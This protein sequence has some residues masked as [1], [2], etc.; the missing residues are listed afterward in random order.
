MFT[1]VINTSE[2]KTFD[3]DILMEL[4]GYNKIRWMT[5]RLDLIGECAKVISESQNVLSADEFRVAVIVDFFGFD[6]IRAPYGHNGFGKEEGV[7]S[8][9]YLPYIDTYLIDNFIRKLEDSDIVPS[10]FE[11]YYVQ[12]G[13]HEKFSFLGNQ[14]EQLKQIL[15]GK[16]STEEKEDLLRQAPDKF[17]WQRGEVNTD[18]SKILTEELSLSKAEAED[19][20]L[21]KSKGETLRD[22]VV[23]KEYIDL[24]EIFLEKSKLIYDANSKYKYMV[25]YYDGVKT[26]VGA[27]QLLN[28]DYVFEKLPLDALFCKI[29]IIDPSKEKLNKTLEAEALDG[30]V[31][32]LTP[33]YGTYELHCTQDISLEFNITDYPYGA[34]DEKLTVPQFVEGFTRRSTSRSKVRRHHYLTSYGAGPARAAFDTLSLSLYLIRLYEREEVI[35]SEELEVKH[36]DADALKDV[37]ETS[38]SKISLAREVAS[39]NQS[40][41]YSLIQNSNRVEV[42]EDLVENKERILERILVNLPKEI[43]KHRMSADTLYHS[44]SK[45]CDIELAEQDNREEFDS[46][47]ANYL[48]ARD[49][50]SENNIEA[51]FEELKEMNALAMTDQC[52]SREEFNYVV[53]LREKDISNLF[54]STLKAE[55]LEVDYSKEKERADKAYE[56]YDRARSCLARNIFAD[57]AVFVLAILVMFVPYQLLQLSD[58]SSLSLGANFLRIMSVSIFAVLFI[59]AMLIRIIPLERQKRRAK[60]TLND[61][62]LE[63]HAKR[64]YSFEGLRRRYEKE[65]IQI[66]E[67]RYEIHQIKH[68]YEENM[69]KEQHIKMH[70]EMLEE[71]QDK[72]S[73]MLNN[74][75]IEPIYNPEETVEG[76]FDLSKS[77]RAKEN[78]V[79]QVFSIEAIEKMFEKNGVR[80]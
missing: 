56:K 68:L 43:K 4:A 72:L 76:E 63:C 2:N 16:K 13:K 25:C 5:S 31:M 50:T 8:S 39:T 26:F 78:R 14:T 10:D 59:L 41:Y 66:E 37:L 11:V 60:R 28:E 71:V 18:G 36:I 52:P 47:I 38:W 35:Q 21:E 51:Q 6:K 17:V 33:K 58:Y 20:Y 53:G 29:V 77:F 19:L 1:Y 30:V 46:I 48:R 74:L 44:I 64:K 70:R 65:L 73:S 45:F 69:A 27:T 40:Q 12:N 7:D 79:Y 23:T 57:I 42:A 3:S 32:K 34:V 62:Y 61:I 22:C 67:T 80:R 55:F 15:A 54:E 24:Q 49:A 9:I 75:N